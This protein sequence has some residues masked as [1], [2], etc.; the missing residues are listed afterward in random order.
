MQKIYLIFVFL[1]LIGCGADGIKNIMSQSVD[2][3]TIL[4]ASEHK[5]YL[6]GLPEDISS[7]SFGY[8]GEINNAIFDKGCKIKNNTFNSKLS[9]LFI[10]S[11]TSFVEQD[12]ILPFY[13]AILDKDRNLK[14]MQYYSIDS[15]FNKD[16]EFN[17]ITEKE[18]KVYKSI[19]FDPL[20]ELDTVVVGFILDKKIIEALD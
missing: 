19:I 10:V 18:I 11:P 12:I 4:F 6:G 3:P 7:D 13:I 2:C 15:K 1:L 16:S 20:N 8:K 17:S 14:D 9:L 5:T